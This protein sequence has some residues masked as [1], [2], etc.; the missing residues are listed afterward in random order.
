MVSIYTLFLL[1]VGEL[2]D[3]ISVRGSGI[4]GIQLEYEKVLI[5]QRQG[6]NS[7]RVREKYYE[8]LFYADKKTQ[9]LIIALK[10]FK[11]VIEKLY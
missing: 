6:R 3:G 1:S 5:W 7:V 11:T 2:F 9:N 4:T 8:R 10:L